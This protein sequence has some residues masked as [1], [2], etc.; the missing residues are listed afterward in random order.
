M[1]FSSVRLPWASERSA[2]LAGMV[3]G[4]LRRG[5]IP[6]DRRWLEFPGV[7]VQG[8]RI[9]GLPPRNCHLSVAV[10]QLWLPE[11]TDPARSV[12]TE[13]P[14]ACQAGKNRLQPHR[15]TSLQ[16]RRRRNDSNDPLHGG[17]WHSGDFAKTWIFEFVLQIPILWAD[18]PLSPPCNTA[19]LNNINQ[20]A[21]HGRTTIRKP[22]PPARRGKPPQ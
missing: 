11:T 15:S 3:S 5:E 6:V 1:V 14:G 18:P 10:E 4:W 19:K 16:W 9:Q 21:I 20:G 8:G 13:M 22:S 17:P 7:R 12:I 2:A